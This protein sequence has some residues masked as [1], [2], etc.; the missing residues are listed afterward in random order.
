MPY[1]VCVEERDGKWVAHVPDLPGC[2]ASHTQRERAVQAVPLAVDQYV[3]WCEASGI[4]I[5]GL[6]GPMIVAEVIRMWEFEDGQMVHAFFASDRPSVLED[7]I[8]EYNSLLVASHQ[9]LVHALDT[10]DAVDIQRQLGDNGLSIAEGLLQLGDYERW[11]LDLFGYAPPGAQIPEE[12]LHRLEVLRQHHVD[13]LPDLTS[14]RGV[15][16]IAGETWSL[17]KVWRVLLWREREL[18][19]LFHQWAGHIR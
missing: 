2:Y 7:E 4:R 8:P 10:M 13:S 3:D 6:T 16:I 19:S 17:R 1:I 18:A 11:Y 15:V 5:S 12:P 14:R 9:T